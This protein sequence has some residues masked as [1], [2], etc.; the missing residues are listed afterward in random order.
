[1]VTIIQL[2]L[3]KKKIEVCQLYNCTYVHMYINIK[4][5]TIKHPDYIYIF[6]FKLQLRKFFH[7]HCTRM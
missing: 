4:C 5:F 3:L 1:M 7:L 6:I 2:K